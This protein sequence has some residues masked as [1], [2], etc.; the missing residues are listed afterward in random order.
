MTNV[1]DPAAFVSPPRSLGQ[2][3]TRSSDC[4][5]TIYSEDRFLKSGVGLCLC[6][7]RDPQPNGVILYVYCRQDRFVRQEC[8]T[9]KVTLL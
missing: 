9:A 5:S 4:P 1:C 2:T 8:R 6:G 7:T 3:V